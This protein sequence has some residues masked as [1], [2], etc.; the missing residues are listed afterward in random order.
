[1]ENKLALVTSELLLS[2]EIV[3]E[4]GKIQAAIG[5]MEPQQAD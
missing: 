2:K 3:D 1:M 5:E 4:I